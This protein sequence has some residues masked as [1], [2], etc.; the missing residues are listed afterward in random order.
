M[1]K[2]ESCTPY[3]NVH[4]LMSS[5]SEGRILVEKLI[6]TTK[7]IVL[8]SPTNAWRPYWK[9]QSQDVFLFQHTSHANKREWGQVDRKSLQG[10]LIRE[11]S[12]KQFSWWF[13]TSILASNAC[14]HLLLKRH[15]WLPQPHSHPIYT[16]PFAIT[17]H[18]YHLVVTIWDTYILYITVI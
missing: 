13:G 17:M 9:S 14:S 3:D 18:V 10:Y 11:T 6:K 15:F 2:M 7:S 16:I 1:S 8:S 12:K 5:S 4:A